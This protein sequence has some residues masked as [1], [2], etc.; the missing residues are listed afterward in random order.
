MQKPKI[1]KKV[2]D[3]GA[4][5]WLNFLLR[6]FFENFF[7]NIK[8]KSQRGLSQRDNSGF[9]MN[10]VI[11]E[12]KFWAKLS[13]PAIFIF[14]IFLDLFYTYQFYTEQKKKLIAST[15]LELKNIHSL[16]TTLIGNFLQEKKSDIETF[17]TGSVRQLLIS[18]NNATF[19]TK[20][21]FLAALEK[22]LL[23]IKKAKNYKFCYILD[24]K[25][26][27]IVAGEGTFCPVI[28]QD[29]EKIRQMD[30]I[31]FSDPHK[32]EGMYS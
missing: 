19:S 8:M 26:E 3:Y 30:K 27:K 10:E 9:F 14:L 11:K 31:F 22:N 21:I 15:A 20:R 17:S 12:K 18:Y 5:F 7:V 1:V 4:F 32:E 29:R 2:C 24:K 16:K 13:V 23:D 28:A 6:L 25:L